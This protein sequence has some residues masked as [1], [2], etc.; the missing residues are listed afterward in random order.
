MAK[1]DQ[2]QLY[3]H[4][5]HPG[6][7]R[8]DSGRVNR[9]VRLLWVP[10]VPCFLGWIA[11]LKDKPPTLAK[12]SAT[13]TKRGHPLLVRN[14]YLCHIAGHGDEIGMQSFE[15]RRSADDPANSIGIRF[16]L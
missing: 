8:A 6:L 13:R 4:Q 10:A 3:V 16:T 11:H 14:E 7:D 2:R 5:L 9:L 1:R 12:R 15:L